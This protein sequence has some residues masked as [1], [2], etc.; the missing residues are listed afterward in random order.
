MS[1]VD[2]KECMVLKGDTVD[3]ILIKNTDCSMRDAMYIA[4]D[5]IREAL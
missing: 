5:K 3:I 2:T 1:D 4:I